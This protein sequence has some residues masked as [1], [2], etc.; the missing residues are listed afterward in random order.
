MFQV[1]FVRHITIQPKES[2]MTNH[3]IKELV[4][5]TCRTGAGLPPPVFTGIHTDACPGTNSC[6]FFR[7]CFIIE[8]RL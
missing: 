4:R 7:G 5:F 1:Y 2:K 6:P 3:H 8:S